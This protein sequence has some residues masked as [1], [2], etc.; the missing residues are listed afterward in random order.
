MSHYPL[1]QELRG[2]ATIHDQSG[3]L[4]NHRPGLP[5]LAQRRRACQDAGLCWL[6]YPVAVIRMRKHDHNP[7]TN[8]ASLIVCGVLAG[9][10][11]A[12]AAFPAVAMSG[13]AAKAGAQAFDELPSELTVRRSPQITYVYANDGKT[14]LTSLYDENRRD[15]PL[16][17][18]PTIMR[19][20]II[21]AEDQRF[22]KH[23]GVDIQGVARAFVAN[24][25]KGEVSQGASTITMQYVRLAIS[26]SA[27]NPQQVVDAS[28]DTNARKLREMRYALAV[29]KQLSKDQILERYLNI[30]AFGNSAFG[31]YAASQVYFGKAPKD[32]K[33]EEAAM[34][35]G[36]VKAP[37]S[38]NPAVADHLKDAVNRRNWVLDQMIKTGAITEAQGQAAKASELKVTGK[39][40]PNGCV[41]VSPKDGAGFFCDFLQRWWQDQEAFGSTPYERENRLK[42]GG[43]TI[44]SSLDPPTQAAA[45]AN[46]ELHLPTMNKGKPEWRALMIAAIEPGTGKVRALATNRN[47]KIDDPDKPANGA[48][49]DPAKKK[50]GIRGNYPNTVNPLMSGGGDI[51]GYQAGSAFKI[52]TMTAALENSFPLSYTINATSPYKS[53]YIIES[54][55]DAACPGTHFYCPV[56]ANPGWMNGSRTM[57]SGFGRSVNTFF[58]PLE[59]RVGAEKAVEM[60]KRLGIQFRSPLDASFAATPEAAHQWGAFTLGV[61]QTTP[62][63]LANAYATLAADGKY[64]E[65]IPVEEIRDHNG[66]RLDVGNPRC[67]QAVRTEVAQAAIDAARCPV[68]D[69][70]MLGK[71]DGATFA[72]GK[73][74]YV[75]NFPVAGKT[76]TTDGEKAA[77]LVM[78]TRQLTVGG[79]MAD[80]DTPQNPPAKFSHNEV[81][82]AVAKTLRDAMKGKQSIGFA[83]PTPQMAYGNQIGVPNVACQQPEAARTALRRAGFEVDING[84]PVDSPCPAGT[85]AKTD[86]SGRAPKGSTIIIYISNGKGASPGPGGGGG[87]PGGGGPGRGIC[88]RLPFRCPPPPPP[89]G[90]G[91]AG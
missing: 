14:L 31:I 4:G 11:V 81:N 19:N 3:G 80:P 59:E 66:N 61:S 71:C 18:V 63:E 8:A 68:G 62:L 9:V 74:K 27:S 64:C 22:Y 30:A 45:K 56:N 37:S 1:A 38:Y 50:L 40:S 75:K 6:T 15:V 76:G 54:S 23:N 79:M 29:E 86:P 51:Y 20:A 82:P 41:S 34:L 43:Y 25:Q 90:N 10:V 87:G 53:N 42:T 48:H 70:S 7:I 47:Y 58:V 69:Q 26:Y 44:I 77:S 36:L 60:A 5:R 65:P 83:A 28:A 67:R 46:V 84:Q 17:D 21:A 85:V 73:S 52:F 13:L 32:L 88:D 2:H 12:A 91:V 72:D 78:T 89:G 49:T 55:S 16:S 33:I 57:W 35:A 24:Q 39:S